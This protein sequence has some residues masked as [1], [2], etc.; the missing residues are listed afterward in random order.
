M[1]WFSIYINVG[2]D[3]TNKKSCSQHKFSSSVLLNMALPFLK[4][5]KL[6]KH[7]IDKSFK[8]SS[9][10]LK[11]HW[12][13]KQYQKKKTKVYSLKIHF[14]VFYLWK[15]I[16]LMFFSLYVNGFR[17]LGTPIYNKFSFLTSFDNWIQMSA[18]CSIVNKK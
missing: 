2:T 6:K 9:D 14:N 8:T 17:R 3:K 7:C 12:I 13:A 18:R 16:L 5:N 1:N 10:R 4:K 11:W 15:D